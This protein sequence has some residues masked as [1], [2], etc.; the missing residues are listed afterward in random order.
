M[1]KWLLILLAGV[2]GVACSIEKA[3]TNKADKII[4]ASN[5]LTAEDSLLFS[6]FSKKEKVRV[7]VQKM[8]VASIQAALKNEGYNCRF[9]LILL[10][11]LKDLSTIKS[12][13]LQN[14]SPSFFQDAAVCFPVFNKRKSIAVGV[15]PYV[16]CYRTD[17][18]TNPKNYSD[19][20]K[21]NWSIKDTND[22]T[23]LYA[24][25][26]AKSSSNEIT[27]FQKKLR[28]TREIFTFNDT[29]PVPK[30]YLLLYSSWLKSS[31]KFQ[32]QM[33]L[34]FPNEELGGFYAD[35]MNAAI[36]KNAR[37]FEY[38]KMLMNFLAEKFEDT[39]YAEKFGVLPHPKTSR[40]LDVKQLHL[41]SEN[42]EK[43]LQILNKNLK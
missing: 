35:R 11:S 43:I 3:K 31:K 28:K 26:Q 40:N 27:Q 32:Q 7:V 19:L 38:A 24:S 25:I 6:A 33:T 17:T 29:L 34:V 36:P 13:Y 1:R 8:S 16:I 21:R 20:F 2:F 39:K 22:L 30:T 18:L 41:A 42:E 15:N 9:S 10:R 23:V 12:S 14:L 37:D 5:F 4:I